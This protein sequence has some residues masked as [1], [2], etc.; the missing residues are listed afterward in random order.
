MSSNLRVCA[1]MCGVCFTLLGCDAPRR[2]PVAPGLTLSSSVRA[3]SALPES[4]V[5]DD[6]AD[7][8]EA[9]APSSFAS[10]PLATGGRANGHVDIFATARQ[11]IVEM[12][13]SFTAASDRNLPAAKGQFEGHALRFTGE[14]VNV[15]A[16]V[17]CMTIVGNRAWIG[18]RIT[19][20]TVNQEEV[21]DAAGGAL[22]FSVVDNGEGEGVSD[23]ASLWFVGQTDEIPFCNTRPTSNRPRPSTVGNVQV[24]PE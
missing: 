3:N 20:A 22:T 7:D 15:H 11:N 6:A 13:Y 14:T 9:L 24:K 21:P 19:R 1:A 5:I 2:D 23:E 16:T 10:T 17:T 8:G 4:F 12:T 18:A